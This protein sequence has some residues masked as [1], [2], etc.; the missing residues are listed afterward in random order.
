[1][2]EPNIPD[3]AQTVTID[4]TLEVYVREREDPIQAVGTFFFQRSHLRDDDLVESF[5]S[6]V[7]NTLRGTMEDRTRPIIIF[8]DRQGSKFLI[9]STEVQAVSAHAPGADTILK[10]IESEEEST[11]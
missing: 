6:I 2:R 7:G 10:A 11:G 4:V 3:G 1:M 5:M 9:E 8:S